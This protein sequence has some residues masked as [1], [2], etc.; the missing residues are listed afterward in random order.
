MKQHHKGKTFIRQSL[1]TRDPVVATREAL[2]LASGH[3]A[4]WKSLR[5][6][7]APSTTADTRDAA[8][9]LLKNIGLSPGEARQGD[10]TPLGSNRHLKTIG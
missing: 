7:D 6:S 10:E 4:F 1:K 3:D 8:T 5:S 9:V 2:K